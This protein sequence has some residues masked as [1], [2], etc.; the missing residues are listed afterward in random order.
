M[1]RGIA[2]RSL[3]NFNTAFYKKEQVFQLMKIKR[4]IASV[5][6]AAFCAAM[7]AGTASAHNEDIWQGKYIGKN[8][9]NIILRLDPSAIT[10][11]FYTRWITRLS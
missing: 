5:T 1:T 10:P 11:L 4:C 6:A 3:Q 7:A 8:D 2:L 9:A